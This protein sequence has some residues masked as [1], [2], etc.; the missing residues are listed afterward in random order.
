M[1]CAELRDLCVMAMAHLLQVE[2]NMIHLLECGAWQA[3]IQ[4][5]HRFPADDELQLWGCRILATLAEGHRSRN[6]EVMACDVVL[7]ASARILNKIVTAGQIGAP[8]L[9]NSQIVR[10]GWLTCCAIAGL[11]SMSQE[12]TAWLV[13]GRACR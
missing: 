1:R 7:T 8:L 13:T 5:M 6:A 9:A 4:C 3:V 11:A 12:N 10:G 2:E